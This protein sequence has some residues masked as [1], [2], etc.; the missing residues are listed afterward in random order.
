MVAARTGSVPDREDAARAWRQG[1][2]AGRRV[3]T[4]RRRCWRPS[5]IMATWCSRWPRSAPISTLRSFQIKTP[6]VKR[7]KNVAVDA[8]R[9]SFPKGGMTALLLAARQGSLDGVAG[10]RLRRRRYRQAAGRR[11]HAAHHGDL[12]RPLRRGGGAPRHGRRSGPRRRGQPDAA[13]HGDRHA[14]ARVAVQPADATA[15]RD[16][17][18]ASTSSSC[19]SR[20]GVDPDP[21]LVRAP[22]PIGIGG[23]GVN[24]SLTIGATPLMKAATT[25]DAVLMKIL[26]DAGAD[27]NMTTDNHT[28]PLMMAAGLNWHDISQ[29]RLGEGLA[30]PRS[31]MLM[32]RGAR[33]E[34]VQRRRP[35]GASRCR[36]ARLGADGQVPARARA[37][38]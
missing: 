16:R 26:L 38:C 34:R 9:G 22:A 10:A 37:P 25:S 1:Q 21:R 15:V 24:A 28:T 35:D 13:L 5:R 20:Y 3:R 29:P 17:W 30:S 23:S 36:A 19:C 14:H 18:T 11:H 2:R 27:P 8:A 33:R 6:E 7:D 12:Q 32:D 31:Q 4:D